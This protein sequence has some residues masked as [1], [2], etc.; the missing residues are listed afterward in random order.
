MN[1]GIKLFWA[2]SGAVIAVCERVRVGLYGGMVGVT[3]AQLHRH[4]DGGIPKFSSWKAQMLDYTR[5]TPLP[6]TH[7]LC[8][9]YREVG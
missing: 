4:C 7:Y 3:Y 2:E 9:E 5:L 6:E 1:H 8:R